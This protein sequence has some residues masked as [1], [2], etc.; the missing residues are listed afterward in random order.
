M[1]STSGRD[2]PNGDRELHAAAPVAAKV[3]QLV[4]A[5]VG[6]LVGAIDV[7]SDLE[8]I[9]QH[10]GHVAEHR[11]GDVLDPEINVAG[12]AAHVE[13]E[14]LVPGRRGANGRPSAR[15]DERLHGALLIA[16]SFSIFGQRHVREAGYLLLRDVPAF[17]VGILPEPVPREGT[18]DERRLL[19]V[20]DHG[21]IKGPENP[22]WTARTAPA[23]RASVFRDRGNSGGSVR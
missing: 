4:R 6:L 9:E 14:K 11:P 20:P 15:D 18:H 7:G 21:A 17:M 3:R 12:R 10:I 22:R 5:A 2:A 23:R 8:Q 16:S 19:A 13:P 1:G